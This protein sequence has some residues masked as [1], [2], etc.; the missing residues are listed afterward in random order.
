VGRAGEHPVADELLAGHGTA[1]P[2]GQDV[3]PPGDPT[4]GRFGRMFPDLEAC[5]V[6]DAAIDAIAGWMA[7]SDNE[8][9]QNHDIPAGFTYL[10]Q[11]IDHDITFDPTPLAAR[12][13]AHG[14]VNF[15]TP[16]FDLDS[17]Y[18]A[19]PVAQPFLYDWKGPRPRGVRLLVGNRKVPDLP[20]N[21]QGR[22]LIGDARNDENLIIAQ[23]HL[24]FIRFHNAVVDHLA[25][26]GTRDD[27]LFETAQRIVRWHYQWIVV[28]EFLPKVAGDVTA[29]KVID[30]PP[31]KAAKIQRKHF[32]WRREPFL[33]VEFSGAAYRFG[34]SM[35]RPQYGVKLIP[36]GVAGL[37]QIPL[38]PT[39]RGF[40]PVPA[41]FVIDWE[42]FFDLPQPLPPPPLQLQ[43]SLLIDTSIAEPL[44]DKLPDGGP[45]LPLR[46]LLRGRK[47]GLPSGQDVACVM[48][49]PPLSDAE[50][51][52]GNNIDE[53]LH[54]QLRRAMPLWYYILC[55]AESERG[56]SGVRLGPVGGRI[57]SEVLV[58]LLE[59]DPNSYLSREPTWQPRE[60][61]TGGDFTMVEL[62][63]FVRRMASAR[64]PA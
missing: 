15:R 6:T 28:R 55:E 5:S 22:A 19:G 35:V 45:G 38:F 12:K 11:F 26:G 30:H 47:L 59:G 56:G 1:V 25:A 13:G 16:R 61:D 48:H 10:G 41:E 54:A 44:H 27:E 31:G 17:V 42:R 51:Q 53:R 18:G 52:L 50:L 29:K 7:S 60:L 8:T 14:L 4:L 2:R 36:Q 58:G 46:N 24:L 63:Q 3:F 64:L 34:H 32:R 57:V 20:R 39:L 43:P 49:E 23:L 21:R 62:V 37:Q 40:R 9:D 33:P